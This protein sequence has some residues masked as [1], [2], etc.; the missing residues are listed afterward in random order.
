M[1]KIK[2]V[3]LG[4]N[5]II[6]ANSV[7]DMFHQLRKCSRTRTKSD[8]VFRRE[9]ARRV[10]WFYPNV[11]LHPQ[12]ADILFRELQELGV[13]QDITTSKL[14]RDAINKVGNNFKID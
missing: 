5:N 10:E 2:V 8:S 4:G 12:N 9:Y 7:T 11:E 14:L 3:G 6:Y 13:I 1:F